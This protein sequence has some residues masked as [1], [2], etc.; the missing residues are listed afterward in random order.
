VF[1]I[2]LHAKNDS[3][4][5]EYKKR[6]IK[7]WNEIAPRYHNRWAKNGNGP[8]KSTPE[9]VKAA[10]IKRGHTV[11]DLACG[12]GAV[13]RAVLSKV[14]PYG[15]VIGIDSSQTAIKI[16]K[17]QNKNK[18]LDFILADAENFSF[19]VRFNAV[20]CQYALFFFPNARKALSNVRRCMKKGGTLALTV[21]G[22]GN[23]VPFF[24]SITDVVT[25]YVADYYPAGAPSL[26]RFGNRTELRKVVT[27]AGFSNIKLTQ[28]TFK[29]SPGTFAE[30]WSN[31]LRYL[32]TP[33]KQKIQRLERKQLR[34]MRSEVKQNTMPY[35]TKSGK[36]VFPWT[37]LILTAKNP[38]TLAKSR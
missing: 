37:V 23:T 29:Y 34:K 32:A 14:G 10:Q 35:T 4:F 31:Y 15:V 20:T 38:H 24:S 1:Y 11:L 2:A 5:I 8:F 9:L 36:I 25:K 30:Y 22:G 12:T 18:N 16:A 13:T 3:K 21:H 7:T 33:L 19:K 17:K 28:F 27:A 26:D 6:L